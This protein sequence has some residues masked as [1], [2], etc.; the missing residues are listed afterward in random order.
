MLAP[1]CTEWIVFHCL[2]AAILPSRIWVWIWKI[3]CMRF[4]KCQ[5]FSLCGTWWR[6]LFS[7][8]RKWLQ[9]LWNITN[10]T[11][12]VLKVKLTN[13]INSIRKFGSYLQIA[14][15][16]SS[17]ICWKQMKAHKNSSLYLWKRYSLDTLSHQLHKMW[18][19]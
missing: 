14:I 13:G 1:F 4:F 2:P 7:I 10:F 16:N 18:S 12:K 17:N 5:Q 19:I 6:N 3:R 8:D 11:K 15:K 9:F